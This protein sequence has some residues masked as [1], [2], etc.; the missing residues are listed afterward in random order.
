MEDDEPTFAE[1]YSSARACAAVW[2]GV[3]KCACIY[4]YIYIYICALA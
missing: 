2:A 4:I 3:G 1:A